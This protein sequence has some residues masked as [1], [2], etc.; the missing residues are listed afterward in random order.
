M[1]QPMSDAMRDNRSLALIDRICAVYETAGKE[2][3]VDLAN[4]I[5]RVIHAVAV[6]RQVTLL[7]GGP[8]AELL[9]KEFSADPMLWT[10]VNV[11]DIPVP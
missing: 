6:D 9:Q 5:M 2:D 10:I 4:E 3:D 7:A 11:A 1:E 8:A